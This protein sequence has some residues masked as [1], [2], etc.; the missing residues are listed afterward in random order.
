MRQLSESE[1]TI[2][3][4]KPG[5]A[6]ILRTKPV[7]IL[8]SSAAATKLQLLKPQH[9]PG[10][11]QDRSGLASRMHQSARKEVGDAQDLK[12]NDC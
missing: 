7:G 12:Q 4:R 6:L 8:V 10:S 2:Q 11:V 9:F 1:E 3:C 5:S